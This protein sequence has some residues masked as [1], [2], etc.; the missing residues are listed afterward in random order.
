[1]LM[2]MI[3]FFFIVKKVLGKIVFLELLEGNF[4]E[5]DFCMC[6]FLFFVDYMDV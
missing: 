5:F 3:F 1:M 6:N 4:D 2:Y